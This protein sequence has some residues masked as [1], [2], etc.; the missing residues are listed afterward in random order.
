MMID[1]TVDERPKGV[2]VIEGFPSFGL[3]STIAIEFLLEQ[4]DAERIGKFTYDELP[5][6]VAIHDNELVHP[7]SIWHVPDYDLVILH[8]TLDIDGKEW[9][10]ADVIVE[11]TEELKAEELITIE[12]LTSESEESKAYTFEHDGLAACGAEELEESV[13]VGITAALMLKS[14]KVAPLFAGAHSQ[15]P[16]G[17]AAAKIVEVLKAYL[18]L[19][20]DLEPLLEKAK[21]FEEKL[22]NMFE[23]AEETQEEAKKRRLNYFG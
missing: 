18:D 3:V 5:A 16:D 21:G 13:L 23:Q 10:A 12:G 8:T 22:K 6:T 17:Q 14:D 7:M 15:L 11:L 20:V 9:E 19:D 4:L 1:Y 2:T